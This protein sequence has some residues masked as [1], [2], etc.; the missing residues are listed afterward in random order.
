MSYNR[1]LTIAALAFRWAPCTL[2]MA[3]TL[4]KVKMLQSL[5]M[6]SKNTQKN[7]R[8]SQTFKRKLHKKKAP[9][10]LRHHS[11]GTFD[12]SHQ[13]ADYVFCEKLGAV[14]HEATH[15]YKRKGTV[16][17]NTASHNIL[18]RAHCGGAS[19]YHTVLQL[20]PPG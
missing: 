9:H 11:H 3:G 15:G 18:G 20:C 2:M 17:V 4:R 10:S 16:L 19:L 12:R 7:K 1:S 13:P 8:K 14:G 6:Q 5:D